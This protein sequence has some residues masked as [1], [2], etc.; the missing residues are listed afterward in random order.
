MFQRDS[1]QHHQNNV[2]LLL[3]MAPVASYMYN[4]TLR[5]IKAHLPLKV[6]LMSEREAWLFSIPTIPHA[7]MCPT[8]FLS[9]L[10]PLST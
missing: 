5:D 2:K 6:S 7:L 8:S 1:T 10:N 4:V 9:F 3:G